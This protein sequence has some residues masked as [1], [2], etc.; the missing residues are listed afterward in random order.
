MSVLLSINC[1]NAVERASAYGIFAGKPKHTAILRF[2]PAL[3]SAAN[4]S[5]CGHTLE[6]GQ[7][8]VMF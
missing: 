7:S 4:V 3:G 5:P 2:T 1:I 6:R 8:A